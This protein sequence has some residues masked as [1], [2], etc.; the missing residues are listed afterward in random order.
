[1]ESTLYLTGT[2]QL[3]M[4]MQIVVGR[5]AEIIFYHNLELYMKNKT[6]RDRQRA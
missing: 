6:E 3:S 5:T 2:T 4:N 1:M